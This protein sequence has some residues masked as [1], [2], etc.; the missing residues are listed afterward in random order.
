MEKEIL[1]IAKEEQNPSGNLLQSETASTASFTEMQFLPRQNLDNLQ[2]A[3]KKLKV[4]SNLYKLSIKRNFLLYEYSVKF[5]H[6]QEHLSTI[7]KRK[8]FS[9]VSSQISETFGTYIYTGDALFATK[10]I[11]EVTNVLS[12]FKK[13]Q[14]SVLICPTSQVIEMKK[15]LHEVASKRPIVKTILELIVKDILRHNPSLKFV[16]NLYGK[17]YD[18]KPV[19]ARN[20][21]NAI[22]IMP[23]F[24]TKIMF[25]EDGIYLNVD[26]KNKILSSTHCLDLINSF[27]QNKAKIQK[28]ECDE[29]NKFF[30]GR[31][32]ETIHTNQRFKIEMVCFDKKANNTSI[33]FESKF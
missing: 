23:G 29:I 26:I 16:K 3:A 1:S 27:I 5:Q 9:K 31:S 11:K 4:Y 24:S 12:V 13:F 2:Y 28:K 33:N 32:V 22:S 10:E 20:E 18:E 8:V 30:K 17:K 7:L 6:E 25:L 21:Y 15:D 19:S 14:Y